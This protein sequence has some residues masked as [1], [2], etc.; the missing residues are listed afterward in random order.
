MFDVTT[1]KF[2]SSA[3]HTGMYVVPTIA[4]A[5]TLRTHWVGAGSSSGTMF[6]TYAPFTGHASGSDNQQYVS[7]AALVTG[8]VGV[9][10]TV[11]I[12]GVMTGTMFG[13]LSATI[14]SGSWGLVTVTDVALNSHFPLG[15]T[16]APDYGV[17]S[18][19][20]YSLA[21]NNGLFIS[22]N[23]Q[24]TFV[25]SSATFTMA[26]SPVG[27]YDT[28]R[29]DAY[30]H[31][32]TANVFDGG[33]QVNIGT[34]TKANPSTI[35]EGYYFQVSPNLSAPSAL[36]AI[37]RS[38]SADVGTLDIG[39]FDNAFHNYSILRSGSIVTWYYDN[40]QVAAA[41]Y[42]LLN[43]IQ[44]PIG[45]DVQGVTGGTN[46]TA[47]YA[48][49][50]RTY[51][52]SSFFAGGQVADDRT[53]GGYIAT[54]P[55][56]AHATAGEQTYTDHQAAPLSV[57]LSGNLRVVVTSGTVQNVTGTVSVINLHPVQ[58]VTGTLSASYALASSG[59]LFL[60]TFS[61]AATGSP[62]NNWATSLTGNW[63][64]AGVEA[65]F[66]TVVDGA[67]T[68]FTIAQVGETYAYQLT[69]EQLVGPTAS[70]IGSRQIRYYR[71][72]DL[73]WYLQAYGDLTPSPQVLGP[74]AALDFTWV[75]RV[76]GTSGT[77]SKISNKLP[78]TWGQRPVVIGCCSEGQSVIA[79]SGDG[80]SFVIF[81]DKISGFRTGSTQ[82][83]RESGSFALFSGSLTT[84]AFHTYSLHLDRT[85]YTGSVDGVVVGSSTI[86]WPTGDPGTGAQLTNQFTL[87]NRYVSSTDSGYASVTA[88]FVS[89]SG[90][91]ANT[92]RS[93]NYGSWLAAMPAAA[94]ASDVLLVENQISPL[95]LDLSGNLKVT[96]QGGVNVNL[97]SSISL[98]VTSTQA[99]PVWITGTALSKLPASTVADVAV[100]FSTASFTLL[101]P[102][103]SRVG[104]SLYNDSNQN[105]LVRYG[106]TPTQ[107]LWNFV[108]GPQE[109]FEPS[110]L[111]LGNVQAIGWQ[112]GSGTI[113][114]TEL[115]P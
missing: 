88:S 102:S 14:G 24:A 85:S 73:N 91:L 109:Y 56:T 70:F 101:S 115:L 78:T 76:S 50:T 15:T 98:H 68:V 34:F 32:G 28:L 20:S 95:N 10:G 59:T 84:T 45:F 71:G 41:T 61:V 106:A 93:D 35:K 46:V 40:V 114:V 5:K 51:T 37:L 53:Y 7:G 6:V 43:N 2:V 12:G 47:S 74:Y 54:L 19:V 16:L 26:G 44:L 100:A 99:S 18:S 21:I 90:N 38:G 83:L 107:V 8:T 9:T 113:Y 96:T 13:S 33:Q 69:A 1:Q 87:F 72:D 66:N 60:D 97:T 108:L 58:A 94:H 111:W 63:M 29:F 110:V 11:I 75:A 4:G 104:F 77:F 112:A 103:P 52:T 80:P 17:T 55:A 36:R 57:D 25:T 92:A 23:N 89:V 67:D 86:W 30:A 31:V 105:V 81:A 48:T 42:S 62:G 82:P 65:A 79:A 3:T 49:I 39:A 64:M 27:S 22:N